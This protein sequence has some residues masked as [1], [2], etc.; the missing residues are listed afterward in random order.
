M[1][2]NA[3]AIAIVVCA[4][5]FAAS[6]ESPRL[7]PVI[8]TGHSD[9]VTSVAR[10][11][12]GKFVLTG[13]SGSYDYSVILWEAATGRPL[14]TYKLD[15]GV[16]RVAFS[17]DD[18]QIVATT[19]HLYVH[20]WETDTGKHLC[21]LRDPGASSYFGRGNVH[22]VFVGDGK[23]LVT[24]GPLNVFLWDIATGKRVRSYPQGGDTA[25]R[26]ARSSDG[27]HV[28]VGS[29]K[30]AVLLEVESGKLAQRFAVHT[31]YVDGVALSPDGKLAVTGSRDKIA[32]LWDIATGKQ[33]QTFR[34]FRLGVENV[35]LDRE[36]K[37]LLTSHEYGREASLWDTATDKELQTFRGHTE[38]I[39][40]VALSPDGKHAY[41][42]SSDRSAILW[43]AATGK[44]LVTFKG[45][46]ALIYRMALAADGTRLVTRS[47]DKSAHVW[48][49]SAGKPLRTLKF[50]NDGTGTLDVALSQD[51]KRMLTRE[52]WQGPLTLLNADSGETI[53]TFQN[54][55]S[56]GVGISRDGKHVVAAGHLSFKDGAILWDANTG[57]ELHTSNNSTSGGSGQFAL[58]ADGSLALSAPDS[59]AILWEPATGKR[60]RTFENTEAYG[61]ALSG[62]GKFAI[63]GSTDRDKSA[64]LWD[65][66]TGKPIQ[67]FP[68]HRG[69]VM[70]VAVSD[71]GKRIA[72]SDEND[73][74]LWDPATGKKLHTLRGHAKSVT[75]VAMTADGKHVWTASHDG[76]TRFWDPATGKERVS[77]A[78]TPAP[79]GWSSRPTAVSTAPRTHGVSSPI[80]TRARQS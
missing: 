13:S 73:A 70:S 18:K 63:T 6:Q 57:E 7:E 27:K 22:A 28:L 56:G 47:N 38:S 36:G 39:H 14:R 53:R 32:I 23:H 60:I 33:L 68:G 77:T 1:K 35:A 25:A 19:Y 75:T 76:T 15:D 12:D 58:S 4:H 17:A 44:K 26:V 40:D 74:I 78:S 24:A 21:K 61:L 66:T 31:D 29:Y 50:P 37:R 20:V 42:A 49:I 2:T 48:D 10:S 8:Q 71:D 11:N 72:T 64:T 51:G 59:K 80:A 55:R 34:G 54:K 79:T 16:M 30:F 3:L 69:T 41:T 5:G 65:A 43:D 9:S 52:V 45:Y 67:T 62:D 46:P